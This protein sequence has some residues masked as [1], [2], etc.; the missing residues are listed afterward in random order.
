MMRYKRVP[1]VIL[2]TVIVSI[3]TV[4][5]SCH[6]E[7]LSPERIVGKLVI[8]G[9]CG[10][11]VIQVISG[12]IAPSRYLASWSNGDTTYTNVFTVRDRCHFGQNGVKQNQKFSFLL[13][14][15]AV[16]QTCMVCDIYVAVPNVSNWIT[17]V[18][19]MP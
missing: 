15:T 13:S 18:Q 10:N 3:A 2:L 19:P 14:D 6:R 16:V 17:D 1:T 8:N 5:A 12:K 4:G 9:A 7:H 11:Y